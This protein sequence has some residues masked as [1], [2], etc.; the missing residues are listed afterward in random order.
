MYVPGCRPLE[1]EAERDT[2]ERLAQHLHGDASRAADREQE[3]W[4][5]LEQRVEIKPALDPAPGDLSAQL[6]MRAELHR[7]RGDRDIS[8]RAQAGQPRWRDG[9][10][11][12]LEVRDARRR[13]VARV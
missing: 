10:C 11:E 9:Q 3:H 1:H 12:A 8:F 4:I 5:P 13:R 7:I 6:K 2:H